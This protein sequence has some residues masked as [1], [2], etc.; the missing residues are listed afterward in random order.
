[1]ADA[2]ARVSG[3]DVVATV[4]AAGDVHGRPAATLTDNGA[5][6]TSRYTGGRNNFE[7]LLACLGIRQKNGSP[8]SSVFQVVAKSVIGGEYEGFCNVVA[9]A[10]T[11]VVLG[12]HLIGPHVAG[13]IVEPS[14]GMTPPKTSI[15]NP[16]I[17]KPG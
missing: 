11:S 3:D 6:Y 16:V 13:L 8:A 12:V 4:T 2:G 7:Y 9:H 15:L 10:E 17:C 5:V 14:L 1:M